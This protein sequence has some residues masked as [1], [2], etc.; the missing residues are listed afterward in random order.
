M[1]PPAPDAATPGIPA[2][3]FHTGAQPQLQKTHLE[4]IS[5]P[6]QPPTM[7][8][9]YAK[10]QADLRAH[11]AVTPKYDPATGKTLDQYKPSFGSRFGRALLDAGEG[12]LHGG[13]RGAIAAPLA[14]AF[15]NKDAPG[16]FG[17]GAVNS[18]YFKD[19]AARKNT[20]AADTA[21]V[22]S[23]EDQN[24]QAQ[25]EFKDKNEVYKDT[26]G[27][28]YKQ[29]LDEIKRQTNDERER[30]N[31]ETE[32]LKQQLQ[33]ATTPE[34]KLKAEINARA[35]IVKQLGLTGRDAQLYQ[36]NGKLPD[37]QTISRRL[38]IEEEKLGIERAKAARAAGEDGG[39]WYTSPKELADYKSR[40]SSLDR[41]AG[42]LESRKALYTEGGTADQSAQDALKRIDDRLNA[43]GQEKE[44]VKQAIISNRPSKKGPAAPGAQ[45][46]A[47][48][49]K[50]TPIPD[51]QM[52]SPGGKI[53]KVGDTV[54]DG[55]GGQQTI[56][57]FAKSPDGKVHATF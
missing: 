42:A 15:G 47:A 28:A 1:G 39:Q 56:K 33:A 14:G 32:D 53:Y 13:V 10:T 19:E 35:S 34:A 29:D 5:P 41:E 25:Q 18:R 44:T 23:F 20:V 38:Q 12:F 16:Y 37:D 45:P 46:S 49:P 3:L 26:M 40:T 27:Q 54:P 51:K 55:K 9:D 50:L 22:G 2:S 11:S 36:A 21:K 4:Q 31:Q 24:K 57:G 6:P 8:A 7:D 43:I 30:H 52:K 17:K 48:A